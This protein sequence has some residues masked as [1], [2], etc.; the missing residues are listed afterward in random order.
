[1]RFPIFT[2]GFEWTSLTASPSNGLKD[3]YSKT[4]TYGMKSCHCVFLMCGNLDPGV[5]RER[6]IGYSN[7][8]PN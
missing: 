8:V 5:K 2:L 7:S 6:N 4:N 1:M 3:D